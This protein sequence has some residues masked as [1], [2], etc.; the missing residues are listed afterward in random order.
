MGAAKEKAE[1]AAAEKKAK[2]E[3]KAKAKA[4]KEAKG[5]AIDLDEEEEEKEEEPKPIELDEEESEKEDEEPEEPE[6]EEEVVDIETLEV[7]GIEDIFEVGGKPINQPLFSQFGFEDWALLTLRFEL[8]L[9]IH[10][11]KKDVKDPERK[12]IHEDNIGFYYQKYFKK[13]LNPA[14]FG[15][16]VLKELLKFFD[17]TIKVSDKKVLETFLPGDSE[18]FNVFILLAEEAR[19]D[20]SRRI[21]MGQEEAK[22]NMQTGSLAA[23]WP[24]PVLVVATS[25]PS[26][27]WHYRGP[28]RTPLQRMQLKPTLALPQCLLLLHLYRL[29]DHRV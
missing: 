19:R 25:A 11:F 21:D 6:E 29:H 24:C 27:S 2:K 4:E 8:N 26:A 28:R 23:W 20:R 3:A 7:F 13:G 17:D 14:F 18:T 15:V 1:K 22:I 16:K 12:E 9:L 10:S 5:E